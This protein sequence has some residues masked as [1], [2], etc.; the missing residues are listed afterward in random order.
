MSSEIKDKKDTSDN[1]KKNHSKRSI[2]NLTFMDKTRIIIAF[3]VIFVFLFFIMY[4]NSKI[5]ESFSEINRLKTEISKVEK[6]NNQ[7]EVSIQSSLNLYNV[8]QAAKD[9][10]G[11]QKL[12][13]SQTI[14]IKL[15]KKDYIEASVP[16]IEM[17]NTS[18]GEGIKSFFESIFN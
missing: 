14:Y 18:F 1:S 2:D 5:N 15:P 3:V 4:R 6:E 9:L 16:A 8:E 7:L 12:T 10:L 17:D 13:N 11:M